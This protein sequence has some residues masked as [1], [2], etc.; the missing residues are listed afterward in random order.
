MGIYV[1][2]LAFGASLKWPFEE[3][4]F[5]ALPHW[6][7]FLFVYFCNLI[8]NQILSHGATSKDSRQMDRNTLCFS[9]DH[10]VNIIV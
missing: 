2:G 9:N 1:D 8:Q 7:H 3:L 4:Q 10:E 6:L 5:L